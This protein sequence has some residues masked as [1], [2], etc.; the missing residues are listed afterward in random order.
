MVGSL[1]QNSIG[2]AGATALAGALTGMKSLTMLEYVSSATSA[3]SRIAIH[4]FS[5]TRFFR[6]KQ[7]IHDHMFLFS[8]ASEGL[9]HACVLLYETRVCF[10]VWKSC[11]KRVKS[12]REVR[13]VC[14]Y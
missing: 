11:A 6:C 12:V 4:W 14:S 9:K 7:S 8:V 2:D 3:T 1:S 13:F 10:I 5:L